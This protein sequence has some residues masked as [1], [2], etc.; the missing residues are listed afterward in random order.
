M[1]T[2]GEKLSEK[3]QRSGILLRE[4]AENTKIRGEFLEFLENNQFDRIP[5]ADVYRRGFLKIY[6]RFLQLDSERLLNDYNAQMSGNAPARPGGVNASRR[7]YE[8]AAGGLGAGNAERSAADFPSPVPDP[9]SRS[10]GGKKAL[11]PQI[12]W[13]AGLFLIVVA[14]TFGA[15]K[16]FTEKTAQPR[17]AAPA[18]GADGTYPL[19][20][21]LVEGHRRP[22]VV[23][24]TQEE[25]G[26]EIFNG[27]LNPGESQTRRARGTLIVKSQEVSKVMVNIGNQNFHLNPG[28][29]VSNAFSIDRRKVDVALGRP[30]ETGR[31]PE[32]PR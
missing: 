5:L 17:T 3:R 24:I 29:T 16:L 7:G 12:L 18:E 8:A 26:R 25:D 28:D 20:L 30:A 22:A 1:Q 21:F 2:I 32:S 14:V 15:R 6:A 27:Y 19:R 9:G 31:S 11:L 13:G 10:T 4:A 23:T